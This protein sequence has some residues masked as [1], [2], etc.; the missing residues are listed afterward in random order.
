MCAYVQVSLFE[1]R[2]VEII[3]SIFDLTNRGYVDHSQYLKGESTLKKFAY[4]LRS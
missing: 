1:E 2:D 3:F 4:C